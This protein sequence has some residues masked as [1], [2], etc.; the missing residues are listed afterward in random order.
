[1]D[2]EPPEPHPEKQTVRALSSDGPRETRATRTV[3]DL[4]A[5]SPQNP[6]RPKTTDKADRNESAQ[7]HAKNTKNTRLKSSSQTVRLPPADSPPGTGTAV[8]A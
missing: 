2:T 8:R 6:S 5:D 1:M 4:K 7:E 3:R